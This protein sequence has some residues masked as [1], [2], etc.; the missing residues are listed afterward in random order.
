MIVQDPAV[1][2]RDVS[3]VTVLR[4]A[5]DIEAIVAMLDRCSRWSL[6]HR[7]HGF[8]D[9]VAYFGALLRNR[10]IDQTLLAWYGSACVGVATLGVAA[11]GIFELSVLVED[12]WQRR[13]IGTELAASLLDRARAQGA[14]TM[15][16][17]I[18]GEDA[19]ILQALRR[20]SPLTVAIER[21]ILSIDIDLHCPELLGT[22]P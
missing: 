9:S 20:L 4:S 19:F 17:D 18:L 3:A 5:A 11:S 12:D 8:T 21:G 13:G 22:R 14:T 16:A 2:F 6:F 10:S 7:F 15:H 1:E